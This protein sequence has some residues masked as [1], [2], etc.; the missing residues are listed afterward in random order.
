MLFWFHSSSDPTSHCFNK[1]EQVLLQQQ[2]IWTWLLQNQ[3]KLYF[4]LLILQ[5][6]IEYLL[7][8]QIWVNTD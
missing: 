5:I 7:Y 2:I 3:N 1:Q 4:Y 6:F 8:A